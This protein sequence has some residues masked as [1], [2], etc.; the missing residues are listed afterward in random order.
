MKYPRSIVNKA[1]RILSERQQSAILDAEK[2]RADFIEKCPELAVIEANMSE[3][4]LEAV[5]AMS[6][7]RNPK[8]II[9]SLRE[10]S[11]GFQKA[12][13]D[14]LASFGFGEDYLNVKYHCSKCK[15]TGYV[16]GIV[17]E[18]YTKLLN[19]LSYEE[20]AN[21]SSLKLSDFESFSLDRYTDSADREQMAATLSLCK[22]YCSEFSTLSPSLFFHGRTGLGKTHLSLAI[23]GEVIKQGY[24]VVYG[25]AHNFFNALERE[26]F[27]RSELPDGTTEEKLINCDLLILD[28]LGSE[29][30]T[31]F[32]VPQLYNI[33]DS[34]L[35]KE[36]PTI[37]NSNLSFKEIESKY[38]ERI[39]S[40][41][42][43]EY[44]KVE[45]VGKD[46]RQF[47]D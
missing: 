27:G 30:I 25:S 1:N 46:N 3:L 5:K 47:E 23:A 16:H 39:A 32:S 20:L 4:S 11:L 18:C 26:H 28:D 31:Q 35:S 45:F 6:T 21:S 9:D 24:N 43:G 37:I 8:E 40:R 10:K 29:F 13:K 17:C 19:K 42:Y 14:L 12:K 22:Q 34:R 38:S 44:V 33:I 36:L 15:D 41:I 7:D 2:R